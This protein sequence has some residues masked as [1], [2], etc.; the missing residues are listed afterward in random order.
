MA[1]NLIQNK[2]YCHKLLGRRYFLDKKQK[3]KRNVSHVTT[4]FRIFQTVGLFQIQPPW[5]LAL[6]QKCRQGQWLRQQL[7]A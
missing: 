7:K 4:S 3:K 1:A 6:D 2:L 5:S